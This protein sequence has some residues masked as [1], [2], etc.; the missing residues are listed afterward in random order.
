MLTI[1]HH[2]SCR[3]AEGRNRSTR[4]GKRVRLIRRT[5]MVRGRP[6]RV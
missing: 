1:I 5:M 2:T 6:G 3:P 4:A